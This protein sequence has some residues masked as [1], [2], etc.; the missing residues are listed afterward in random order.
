MNLVS[1]LSL[2]I[3]FYNYCCYLQLFIWTAWTVPQHWTLRKNPRMVPV[4]NFW[5][6]ALNPKY[7]ISFGFLLAK[8]WWYC[9]FIHVSYESNVNKETDDLYQTAIC[10]SNQVLLPKEKCSPSLAR[11]ISWWMLGADCYFQMLCVLIHIYH[12]HCLIWPSFPGSDLCEVSMWGF[13]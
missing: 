9:I 3:L 12:V 1:M 6:S 4:K 11:N 13:R 5:L 7:Q 8:Y 10:C 2:Y